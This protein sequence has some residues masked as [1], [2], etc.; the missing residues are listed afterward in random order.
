M[1]SGY[2][3][4][5]VSGMSL[6]QP[7]VLST[8]AILGALASPALA[9]DMP[10]PKI[11]GDWTRI[12]APP[13]LERYAKAGVQAVDFTIFQ[14]ADGTWQLVS[15]I[16]GTSAPG[17]GRLLY[18]WESPSLT[19]ADWTAKGI[20]KEADPALGHTLGTLQAPYCVRD[21]DTWWMFCNSNGAQCLTSTDGK[22]FTWAVNQQ[23]SGKFFDMGRDVMIF[24][25]RATDGQWYA[26]YTDIRKSAYPLRNDH[27]VSY[28]RA[29]HLD[30]RWS[31][32]LDV[33]VLTPD[34]ELDP[35]YNFADA[36]SPFII[37]RGECYYRWEHMDVYASRSLTDWKAAP[38]VQLVPGRRHAYL[39]PEIVDDHGV[40]YIAAYGDYGRTGI[41]IARLGW[42][43]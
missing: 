38:R 29:E 24:D 26:W 16:R 5:T 19:Q 23:K 36:E 43:E 22:T 30:G 2:S 8:L 33:G 1:S 25:N 35:K 9:V 10:M 14:A 42:S 32:S 34:A 15:C 12:A 31:A 18:R 41:F 40:S 4:P 13:E 37:K 6:H 7:H 20:F 27:T 3:L 39:A 21:G 11:E 28:R 17:G